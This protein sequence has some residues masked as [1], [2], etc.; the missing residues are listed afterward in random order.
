MPDSP[1]LYRLVIFDA[2]DD[3]LAL[4]DAISGITG[5]HPTDA[6]QWLARAP[7]VW[8]HPLDEATVRRILD[9]L[10]EARVAAEARRAD[11]FPELGPARTIHRAACLD[12]GLRTEGLRGEPTH[13]IPWDR[14]ELICAGR[15]AADDEYRDPA[16]PRWPSTLVSG[17]RALA[18]RKP[19]P[20]PRASRASRIPRDPVGEVLVVRRDPRVC[21]RVVENQMNY[22]YL[23]DRL[24]ETASENFPLLLADLCARARDAYLTP[25]TRAWIEGRDPSEYEFPTS[26]ALLEYATHRLL[27][28]WYRRDGRAAG[29]DAAD[30]TA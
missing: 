30:G 18:A 5:L 7:G 24:R 17:I 13:W 11:Q 14:V 21:I 29:A 22:A 23:G 1:A 19:R 9:A 27:W 2:I 16:A 8:P 12:D 25:S 4:R 10:Y 15:I 20:L 26:Q 6:V 3:P 28:S